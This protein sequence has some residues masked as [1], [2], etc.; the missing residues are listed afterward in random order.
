MNVDVIWSK[1][2]EQIKSEL[3]SLSYEAWFSETKLHKLDN[4]KAYIIVPMEIHK[5]HILNNYSDIVIDN[6]NSLTGTNYEIYLLSPDE[7]EEE[8]EKAKVAENTET[9]VQIN[10]NI[11]NNLNPRYTFYNFIVGNSNKFAQASAL[12]VAENPGLLYNPLFLYGNSGLGKTHLMHA[13]GNYI[14]ENSNKRVL[15]VTSEQFRQDFVKANRKDE[16]GTN[17][18]YVD[19][20]KDKYRNIDVLLIDDIQFLEGASKSQE[21]FFHTFNSLHNNGKQIIISSDRS[22]DDLKKLEERL[23]TRFTWGL[24]ANI[25][26]PELS[27]KKEI[28]RKKIIAN[29]FEHDIPEEVIE[30]MANNI[31]PDV[32]KLEG[33][34][35]RLVAYSTIMGG[36]KI[37]L[38]LAIEALK[39]NISKGIGEKNNIQRIQR[40]VAEYFQIS[41]EDLRSKKR[42][43]N[44]SF[45]RQIAMYL[46]RTMTTESFPKIAIEFGGK[47]HTTVMYSV[48]KIENE[49]KINKDLA[50][51]I[52]KLKKD[53]GVV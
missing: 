36:E 50:N 30:Y 22:P 47:D 12:S 39:D 20:F 28:L 53:I 9:P 11:N 3:N 31:G 24:Q 44:I 45:P 46:C 18:N 19:F 14:V 8:E 4:G 48:E 27:L 38:D 25:Y 33:A 6:L 34:V 7:I 5:K 1:V 37:T 16:E 2:L 49:I 42:S 26:P 21:E 29:D 35:T 43:A 13:I 32:R 52:E 15:Y 40:I 51:I 23:R 17:F 41:T 10:E